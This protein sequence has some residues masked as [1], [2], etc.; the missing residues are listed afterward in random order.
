M[1]QLAEA[2]QFE[3]APIEVKVIQTTDPFVYHGLYSV[4]SRAN[5][6]FCRCQG[7]D[8]LGYVGLR[9]G[10]FPW[11]ATYNRI[12]LLDDIMRDGYRGWV[13]YLDAD[14]YVANPSFDIRSFLRKRISHSL[15]AAPGGDQK[16]NINAGIL[17][18]N[19]ACGFARSVI[20]KWND[21]FQQEVGHEV[22]IS[23]EKPWQEG[24]RNDQ[25][26]LH[27]VLMDENLEHELLVVPLQEIGA[28]SSTAIRQLL[29][30]KGDL[31]VRHA[32]AEAD[33]DDILSRHRLAGAAGGASHV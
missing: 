22:L 32:I 6:E 8:Y 2:S 27:Q 23:A 31:A 17:M 1:S 21:R 10:C 12:P 15:I 25:E 30:T 5:I 19:F 16:W 11:H 7:I 3:D 20:M 28:P 18:F 9:V 29:R 33:V 13:I 14:S 24:I 4:T 26:L